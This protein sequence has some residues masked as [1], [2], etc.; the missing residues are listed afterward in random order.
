MYKPTYIISP[1][2]TFDDEQELYA[3]KIGVK[4]ELM[5]LL[6]V[7][8]GNTGHESRARAALLVQILQSATVHH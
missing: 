1:I 3:T 6:Y 4:S 5:P 2:T 7:A 8:Y